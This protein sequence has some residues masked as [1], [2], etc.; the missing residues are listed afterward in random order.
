MI[1]STTASTPNA[2]L[3][4]VP[5]IETLEPASGQCQAK[6]A[7]HSVAAK[8]YLHTPPS[9]LA[10]SLLSYIINHSPTRQ[11]SH[12]RTPQTCVSPTPYPSSKSCPRLSLSCERP[13][14]ACGPQHV[15][16]P[17]ANE[18]FNPIDLDE[19]PRLPLS[20]SRSSLRRRGVYQHTHIPIEKRSL[21]QKWTSVRERRS[22]SAPLLRRLLSSAPTLDKK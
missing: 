22:L 15:R 3:L 8:K 11:R 1:Q 4:L 10:L 7:K 18:T 16:S 20:P 12:H 6:L 19:V 5:S 13:L 21:L 9:S 2:L 14:R 17:S